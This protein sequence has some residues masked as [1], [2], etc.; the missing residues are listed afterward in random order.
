MN[1]SERDASEN[2]AYALTRANYEEFFERVGH[3]LEDFVDGGT[4]MQDA[5]DC[6]AGLYVRTAMANQCISEMAAES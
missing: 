2:L 4:P 6:V 1:E 3:A 5:L